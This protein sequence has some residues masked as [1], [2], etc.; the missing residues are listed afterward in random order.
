MSHEI[1]DAINHIIRYANVAAL[2]GETGTITHIMIFD[3][4]HFAARDATTLA[5]HGAIDDMRKNIK[6]SK[7]SRR[8]NN[9]N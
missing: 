5:T 3:A 1:K 2:A 7:L 8:E 6:S 4:A 9:G